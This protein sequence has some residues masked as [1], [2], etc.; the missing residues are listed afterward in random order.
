MSRVL[1]FFNVFLLV[2]LFIFLIWLLFSPFFLFFYS[3]VSSFY[4]FSSF[5][6]LNA[7]DSDEGT[8]ENENKYEKNIKN[9]QNKL[10]K[11]KNLKNKFDENEIKGREKESSEE[12][13][14]KIFGTEFD[15]LCRALDSQKQIIFEMKNNITTLETQVKQKTFNCSL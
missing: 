13:N 4:F 1:C 5:L 2:F 11:T 12:D 15:E 8:S 7:Y 3:F 10:T 14:V 9:L 6:S